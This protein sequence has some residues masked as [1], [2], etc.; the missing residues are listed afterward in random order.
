MKNYDSL[1]DCPDCPHKQIHHVVVSEVAFTC[2]YCESCILKEV[3]QMVM[4]EW[5]LIKVEENT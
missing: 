4:F 5:E 1:D 3:T 2:I